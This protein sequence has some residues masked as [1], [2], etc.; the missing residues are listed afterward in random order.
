MLLLMQPSSHKNKKLITILVLDEYT[1]Y[2]EASEEEHFFSSF[3]FT[4]D[5][6]FCKIVI[7]SP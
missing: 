2:T 6:N 4:M 5:A 3:D 1:E 7:L